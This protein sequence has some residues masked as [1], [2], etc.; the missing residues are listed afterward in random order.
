MR[1]VT[2]NLSL[3]YLGRLSTRKRSEP[4][5]VSSTNYIVGLA[6]RIKDTDRWLNGCV[7]IVI[8]NSVTIRY[9]K[10][11][12]VTTSTC[13]KH[14]GELKFLGVVNDTLFHLFRYPFHKSIAKPHRSGIL[15][16]ISKEVVSST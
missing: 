4:L 13:T 6:R 15:R 16:S 12:A 2:R 1:R 7:T 11:D 8:P 9:N 10:S 14:P 3:H 5:D